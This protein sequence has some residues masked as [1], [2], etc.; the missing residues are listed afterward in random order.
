MSAAI[1]FS[2]SPYRIRIAL[3]TPL[4]PARDSPIR[5]SGGEA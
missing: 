5:T 2:L 3:R 4:T 1:S